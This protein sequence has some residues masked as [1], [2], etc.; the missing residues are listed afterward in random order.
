MWDYE[1]INKDLQERLSPELYA[2]SQNVAQIA[3][4]MAEHYKAD[5]EKAYFAGLVHDYAKETDPNELV[6]IAVEQELLSSVLEKR[7]PELLHAAVGA[8]LIQQQYEIMDPD[9][10]QA[11]SYHTLGG[12][13]MSILAKIVYIAD[14]I[15]STRSIQ[16]FENL[17]QVA[18]KNIDE[19]IRRCLDATIV[20][21]ISNNRMLHPRSI[22]VRNHF[23]EAVLAKGGN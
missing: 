16:G 2:H 6:R 15:E 22:I 5:Q 21:C 13:D 23:Q 14:K 7:T 19:A 3:K 4:K 11:I 10:V 17:E 20:N 12:L 9:I 18:Y 1:K 8:F